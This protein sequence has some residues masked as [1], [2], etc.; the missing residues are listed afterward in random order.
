[1]E[2]LAFV[3][4]LLTLLGV[5][6]CAACVIV[7]YEIRSAERE[8]GRTENAS[9]GSGGQS[10]DASVDSGETGFEPAVG[11]CDSTGRTRG[12]SG[13]IGGWAGRRRR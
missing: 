8:F 4:V 11:S 3:P 2:F 13:A 5:L 12:G 7:D 6:Y 10:P 9:A 1:M